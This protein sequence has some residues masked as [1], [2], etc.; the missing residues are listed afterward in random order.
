MKK[1]EEEIC[2]QK[3]SSENAK[4]VVNVLF[5]S[6]WLNNKINGVL[7]PYGISAEQYNVLRILKGQHPKPAT[8]GLV[9]ERMLEKMS[10]ATRLVDKL[11]AKGMVDRRQCPANRRAVDILITPK[12]IAL[13]EEISPQMKELDNTLGLCC[14][15]SQQLNLLLDK[16]R[17]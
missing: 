4:A 6:G 14:E 11:I 10:N 5:T 13:L 8:L 17:S 12:G 9:Q 2:Q 3:F 16:L 15:E 1:I 7:K